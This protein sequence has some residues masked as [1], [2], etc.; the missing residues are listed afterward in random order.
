[1]GKKPF[2]PYQLRLKI[3]K[4]NLKYIHLVLFYL[5]FYTFTSAQLN[6]EEAKINNFII[7][8]KDTSLLL[9]FSTENAVSQEISELIKS[10]TPISFSFDIEIEKKRSFYLPDKTVF[11]KAI[12]HKLKYSSLTKTF[13][14]VK[15][16]ISDEPYVINS[17]NRAQSEMTSITDY[18]I[19]LPENSEGLYTVSVRA[20]LQEV[21]LPFYMHKIFFFLSAWDFKTDWIKQDIEL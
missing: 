10:G 17:Q 21:T 19:K 4:K 12:T 18:K 3:M 16:Y 13:F 6:A 9:S 2:F 1:M 15:P 7:N 11:K 14:I 5:I 20:R 8:K